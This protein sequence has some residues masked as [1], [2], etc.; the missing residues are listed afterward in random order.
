MTGPEQTAPAP[1]DTELVDAARHG[2]SDAFAELW[3]R[4]SSAGRTVARSFSTEDAEDVVAEAYARV[5]SAVRSGGGPR[6]GFRPYLFTTIRNVAAAWGGSRVDVPIDDAATIEDPTSTEAAGL[7][8]LD[9]SLTARAFR[10][11]PERWQEVLW[12]TEVER[13]APASVAPLLGLT[14]NGTAALAYRAREGLRQAWI[15]AHI[16]ESPAG[17][18]C[19][20]TTERLGAHSRG[21]L[22]K[23]ETARV[24]RHLT[25]CTRCTIVAAEAREV[26]SRLA[27]ILLPLLLGVSGAA[28]YTAAVRRGAAAAASAL[29]ATVA[30]AGPGTPVPV[31]PGRV[32]L[33]RRG[34]S[35]GS[36]V[37]SGAVGGV[38][39]AVAGV[40]VAAG[41]AG[42]VVLGPQLLG[43]PAREGTANAADSAPA[44]TNPGRTAPPA[45]APPAA[46]PPPAAAA[47][48]AAVAPA[49]PD[50]AGGGANAEPSPATVP[51]TASVPAPSPAP[52]TSSPTRPP[53]PSEPVVPSTPPQTPIAPPVILSADTGTGDTAGLLAPVLTGTAE[54]GATVA[55]LDHGAP[56]ATTT[57]DADGAWTS[58]ELL[59]VSADY[60]LS[61]QQ[62]TADGKT[63]EPC[64]P[65]SGTV[66]APSITAS[67]APG[68]VSLT[69]AGIPGASVQV[70]ADRRPSSYTLTLDAAGEAAQV[71]GW[72]AGDHRI[73][74]VYLFGARRGILAD[75]PVTLP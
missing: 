35:R 66:S 49:D 5:L 14:P 64:A 25:D 6:T 23:R 61:A 75:V 31:R 26:G 2:D 45:A 28:A 16:A 18:D 8:A 19:R 58:P 21:G 57:A 3:R 53:V 9:R 10:S 51:V 56:L 7:E 15:Q 73:G 69:V 30:A 1:S 72:T 52:T 44:S 71:Y 60:A 29:G 47:P 74:A 13:M 4:H 24:E 17:S 67:G 42:A 32:R 38:I 41:V 55:I 36:G 11:L 50:D 63:S 33:G 62:T 68:T 34:S 48:G 12:Y 20:W 43:S 70:W 22:G 46:T 59:L 37:G 54:P 65:L 40:V 27:L 39:L